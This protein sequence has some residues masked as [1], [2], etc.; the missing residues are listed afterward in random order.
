MPVPVNRGRRD[1]LALLALGLAAPA[2]AAP[3]AGRATAG[4][5]AVPVYTT[6][7]P[8]AFTFTYAVRRGML[9]GTGEL[10][11]RPQG[12]SYQ[13]KL[14]AQVVVVG[15]VLTQVSRGGIEAAGLAPARFT[16]R[17]L[18]RAEQAARFDREAGKVT[19]SGRPTEHPL[20]PGMQDRLSWMVQVPA[21]AQ[22]DP[23]RVRAGATVVL[24]VAG[25]RGD[26]KTWTLRSQ[27]LQT[28]RIEGRKLQAV[29][30]V[31]EPDDPGDTVAEIWLDPRRHH[32]PVRARLT[33]GGSDPLELVLQ[34][35]T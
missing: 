7:L 14:E 23:S 18:R 25:A 11:W 27:G 12:A 31:R 3:V 8:P 26:V 34:S 4:E 24:V 17:R 21:I 35:A 9:G 29:R 10:S 1:S 33:D 32:L 2:C 28:V 5:P 6:Q 22:A 16:D 20:V 19:F 15:A 30:L 13:L